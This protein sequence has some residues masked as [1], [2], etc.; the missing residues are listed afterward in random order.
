[1]VLVALS[2]AG[3]RAQ[4]GGSN[5]G[6]VMVAPGPGVEAPE[7]HGITSTGDAWLLALPGYPL[8]SGHPVDVAFRLTAARTD[9]VK[10]KL[11]GV[12]FEPPGSVTGVESSMTPGWQ[13]PGREWTAQVRFPRNGCWI[14]RATAEGTQGSFTVRVK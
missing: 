12:G 1:M 6:A 5:C 3:C 8:P 14:I 4:A 2:I 13:R 9:S 7:V 11:E 10:V